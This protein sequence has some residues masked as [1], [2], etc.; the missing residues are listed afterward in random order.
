MYSQVHV[1]L[2]HFA[3][4]GTRGALEAC[5]FKEAQRTVVLSL[6]GCTRTHEPAGLGQLG[7]CRSRCAGD[8]PRWVYAFCGLACLAYLHLDCLDGK[9]ARRTGSSSP[10]GQ[11]FDHGTP[12]FK[13]FR[14]RVLG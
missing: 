13:T 6:N 10:L 7:L 11:L 3:Q 12:H 5:I 8:A 1:V 9:Q 2:P 4:H 14:I